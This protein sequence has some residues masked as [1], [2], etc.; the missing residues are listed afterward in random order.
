MKPRFDTRFLAKIRGFG[1]K[2]EVEMS[3]CF[4][5]GFHLARVFR[6]FLAR[7]ALNMFIMRDCAKSSSEDSMGEYK[8]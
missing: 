3:Y 5:V 6:S 8:H 4:I 2:R 1:R 7:R